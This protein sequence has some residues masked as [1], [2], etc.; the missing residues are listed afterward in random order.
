[1]PKREEPIR[2]ADAILVLGDSP[3]SGGLSSLV[4][5][6]EQ[7]ISDLF[8]TV[9]EV[10]AEVKPAVPYSMHLDERGWLAT[11][12]DSE[13]ANEEISVDALLWAYKW[14]G[15]RPLRPLDEVEGRFASLIPHLGDAKANRATL[16]LAALRD[17]EAEIT[18]AG[19]HW[20]NGYLGDILAM[21]R[22]LQGLGV[23]NSPP[24]P[25]D[26]YEYYD[27]LICDDDLRR[28]LEAMS[29]NSVAIL[30]WGAVYDG[31][32]WS[33]TKREMHLSNDDFA[34]LVREAVEKERRRFRSLEYQLKD[35]KTEPDSPPI[36]GADAG[37]QIEPGRPADRV[38][39]DRALDTLPP[40]RFEDVVAEVLRAMG[41]KD[42]WVTPRTGDQGVDV[43]GSMTVGC[44]AVPLAVQAKRWNGAVHAP[45]IREFRGSM[46]PGEA[47]MIVT[48]G[49]FSTGAVE[50]ANRAG[51]APITLINRS[52][53]I[54]LICEHGIELHPQ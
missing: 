36:G 42:V 21:R 15:T 14:F 53:I 19:L 9:H 7:A 34:L 13:P 1:M 47:G 46:A 12:T 27:H 26:L 35:S 37:V 38:A 10:E 25:D 54:D 41:V 45:T 32:T 52:R 24:D 4:T 29:D 33:S 18:S 43:R 44:V 31:Y 49:E 6:W 30:P 51:H 11:I 28:F 5:K 8:D 48:T 17:V 23:S 39:V 22:E 40:G 3:K 2:F 50:E 16:A 20:H